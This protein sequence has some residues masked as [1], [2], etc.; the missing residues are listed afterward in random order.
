VP[1]LIE[2][3]HLLEKHR[4]PLLKYLMMYLKELLKDF[5][6]ELQDIVVGD[7]QLA[8][9]LEY[10]F[11]VVESMAISF[12]VYARVDS[13]RYDLRMWEKKSTSTPTVTMLSPPNVRSKK[14]NLVG[15]FFFFLMPAK[16]LLKIH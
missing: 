5:K 8:K 14:R 7:K 9:E 13:Y 15:C 16:H 2:L 3:K 1:I 4:S 12:P 6:T 10:R 11:C